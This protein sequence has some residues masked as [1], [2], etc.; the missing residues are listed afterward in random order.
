MKLTPEQCED[1]RRRGA[2]AGLPDLP[3]G[4]VWVPGSYAA[5][6]Y[7]NRTTDEFSPAAYAKYLELMEASDR[8]AVEVE[9]DELD[10]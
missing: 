6:A 4:W 7:G 1:L 5:R 3:D 8:N 9:I 2:E 10:G